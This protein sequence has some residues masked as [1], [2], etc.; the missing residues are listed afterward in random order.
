MER[1]SD[2][3]YTLPE[4]AIAQTP[5]ADRT[6]SKL[7]HLHRDT[8]SIEHRVFRKVPEILRP[9]DLLILNDTRV[10]AIRVFGKKISGAAVEL[11]LLKEEGPGLFEALAKPG[12]RLQPGAQ[13]IFGDLRAEVVENRGEGR[14]LVRFEPQ[15]GLRERL[16][17]IG[18]VPLP[19]YIHAELSDGERYQTVYG[20]TPGSAAAPTAGL[21]FTPELLKRVEARGV[22]IAHVTLDVGIDTF[23]PVQAEDLSQ[24]VMHGE[25]C[26]VPE[27]TA[28]AVRACTGRVVAVGTTAVR[29]L[30]SFATDHRLLASGSKRTDIFIRPGYEFRIV[31]GMFTNFHMPRTTMLIMLSALVPRQRLFEAYA[32][33]LAGGY[34]FLS[35]GDSM[36]I[37]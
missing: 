25:R 21:H 13:M 37:L 28:E 4:S 22:R 8:L 26:S 1:L 3:D 19:P 15:A 29:T 16:A 36:L 5:L 35:F 17:E 31:D 14:K 18:S 7:L 34:R 23:R 12:K 27:A 10:S 2:Y 6:A 9:G 32:E 24:H 20:S 11:L 33:A 30:E